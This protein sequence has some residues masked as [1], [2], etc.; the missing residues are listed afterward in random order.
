MFPAILRKKVCEIFHDFG[1]INSLNKESYIRQE[2]RISNVAVL[3]AL[4]LI[5][6]KHF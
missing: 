6:S 3:K 2:N 5:R 1:I 4:F